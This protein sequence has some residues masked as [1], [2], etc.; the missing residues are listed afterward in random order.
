MALFSDIDWI[1]ILAVATFLLFGPENRGTMR[2]IGRW[3]GRAMRLKQELLEEFSRAADLPPPS[4]GSAWSIRGVL[5]D[6]TAAPA[7]RSREA[8]LAVRTAPAAEAVS[9]S[10]PAGV[11]GVAWTGGYPSPAWSTSSAGLPISLE[12]PR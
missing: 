8:T 10:V 4:P 12:E 3:Y 9:V 2:T 7:A 5:L 11:P 1:I 6:A